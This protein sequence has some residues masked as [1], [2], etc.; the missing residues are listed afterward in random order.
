MNANRL[1]IYKRLR[2]QGYPASIALSKAK[3]IAEFEDAAQFVPAIVRLRAEEEIESY[4][5]VYGE[6]DS[7]A[8]RKSI[9][10][11][12]ERNGCVC[13]I[14]EYLDPISRKWTVAASIGFCIY[15]RPLDPIENIYVPD[16]MRETLDALRKADAPDRKVAE[17][18][19]LL[20]RAAKLLE[21]ARPGAAR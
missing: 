10:E 8:D 6:P 5:D 4:F 1:G 19:S 21:N 18:R 2:E 7:E 12:I 20:L 14:G 11:E 16:I 3:A 17:A 13:I 9:V 15:H